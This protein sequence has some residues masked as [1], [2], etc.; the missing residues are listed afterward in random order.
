[1]KEN[2]FIELRG[3]ARGRNCYIFT[4]KQI[5]ISVEN[6]SRSAHL[7]NTKHQLVKEC[8]V[9]HKNFLILKIAYRYITLHVI[10]IRNVESPENIFIN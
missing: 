3:R 7:L 1:M 5:N 8:P 10:I 4:E 2:K 6:S 9:I